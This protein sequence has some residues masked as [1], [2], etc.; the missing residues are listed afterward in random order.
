MLKNS[1]K[2][3][4][5]HLRYVIYI[6]GKRVIKR[7]NNSQ[8][9]RQ[10]ESEKYKN[11]ESCL[12]MPNSQLENIMYMVFCESVSY[13]KLHDYRLRLRMIYLTENVL[14]TQFT[15]KKQTVRRPLLWHNYVCR[16]RKG[17]LR[18]G[19]HSSQQFWIKRKKQI[20]NDILRVCSS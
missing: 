9:A 6:S 7:F 13:K 20:Y 8:L 10:R 18:C 1:K 3:L 2:L 4:G 19:L 5:Y 14:S 17:H 15:V 16:W 11:E 12:K